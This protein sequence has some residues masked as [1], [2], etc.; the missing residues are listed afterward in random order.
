MLK[1][2]TDPKEIEVYLAEYVNEAR[3]S[4]MEPIPVISQKGGEIW[5]GKA[6]PKAGHDILR[7]NLLALCKD[8]RTG[9]TNYSLSYKLSEL[10]RQNLIGTVKLSGI[11][12]IEIE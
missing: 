9:E 10:T 6:V 7:P 8:H 2:I 1:R 4:K 11:E 3:K 5:N 12:Y